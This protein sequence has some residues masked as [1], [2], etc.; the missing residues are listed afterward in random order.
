MSIPELLSCN[1]CCIAFDDIKKGFNF[2]KYVS[3][4]RAPDDTMLMKNYFPVM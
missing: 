4:N 2:N 3:G 1:R